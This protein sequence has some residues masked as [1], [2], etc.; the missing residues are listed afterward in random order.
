MLTPQRRDKF[1][2]CSYCEAEYP[3][4]DK[5]QECVASHNLILVPIAKEDLSRLLQFIF[6]HEEKLLSPSLIRI[7]QKYSYQSLATSLED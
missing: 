3:E 4:K 6:T 2:K 7:I 1:W 5:A